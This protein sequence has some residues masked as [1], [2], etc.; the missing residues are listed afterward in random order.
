MPRRPALPLSDLQY[1]MHQL[2]PAM[3][4]ILTVF[5]MESDC[6]ELTFEGDISV[7]VG[8]QDQPPRVLFN[9][10]VGEVPEDLREPVYA[11]LLVANALPPDR[12]NLRFALNFTDEQVLV[13]GELDETD[14]SLES[15]CSELDEFLK[16]AVMISSFMADSAAV[17]EDT[18]FDAEPA[19]AVMSQLI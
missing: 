12:L 13:L 10:S 4:E 17:N 15:L 6:W 8:W 2:G 1:L 9:C 3:P 5:Q 11:R 14:L 16:C 7:E 19:N 18:S